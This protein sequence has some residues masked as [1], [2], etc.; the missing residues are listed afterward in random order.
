MVLVVWGL[1]FAVRRLG[2]LVAQ[3]F[4]QV[5]VVFASMHYRRGIKGLRRVTTTHEI[6]KAFADTRLYFRPDALLIGFWKCGELGIEFLISGVVLGSLL[7]VFLFPLMLLC[8]GLG[9][10]LVSCLSLGTCHEAF[11]WCVPFFDGVGKPAS[12]VIGNR[13]PYFSEV[14][15]VVKL[16]VD[17]VGR[18]LLC[19]LEGS[20]LGYT[21]SAQLG[22]RF[23]YGW[24]YGWLK[25]DIKLS[26]EEP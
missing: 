9:V 14:R 22:D 25:G 24:F 6:I 7:L 8:L 3:K 5:L 26:G 17:L 18:V 1:R 11:G 23:R 10:C 12:N 20:L 15:Q 4:G 13:P 19:D 21:K 16:E 2:S